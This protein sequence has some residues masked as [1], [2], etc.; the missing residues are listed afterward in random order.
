MVRTWVSREAQEAWGRHTWEGA[1]ERRP[2]GFGGGGGE[3]TPPRRMCSQGR[4][5]VEPQGGFGQKPACHRPWRL[6]PQVGPLGW[7]AGAESVEVGKGLWGWRW[8]SSLGPGKGLALCAV[9]VKD[10][11]ALS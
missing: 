10:I 1:G 4:E 2:R 5:R 7:A 11:L 6:E 9:K 8:R 3:G